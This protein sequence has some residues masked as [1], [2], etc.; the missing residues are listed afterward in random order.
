MLDVLHRRGSNPR[1]QLP[2][3]VMIMSSLRII[4]CVDAL[5]IIGPVSSDWDIA[6]HAVRGLTEPGYMHL[7][8]NPLKRID[9]RCTVQTRT[10]IRM[11]QPNHD[12]VGCNELE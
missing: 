1:I 8:F 10:R 6:E 2:A 7:V 5:N 11:F 3:A 4:A 12:G 9:E